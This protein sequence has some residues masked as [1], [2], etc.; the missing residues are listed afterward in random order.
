MTPM[1][2]TNQGMENRPPGR[3]RIRGQAPQRRFQ[4]PLPRPP[5]P[6]QSSSS[7]NATTLTN[8]AIQQGMQRLFAAYNQCVSRV[9]QTDDRLEQFRSAIRRDALELTLNMQRASQD[10]QNQGQ[11]IERI[12][13]TLYD[14][15]RKKVNHMESQYRMVCD[16]IDGVTQL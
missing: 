5:P 12:K 8:D 3:R 7:D 14:E 13:H 9:A 2:R 11:S 10:L 4:R 16:H 15:M 1:L 6:P